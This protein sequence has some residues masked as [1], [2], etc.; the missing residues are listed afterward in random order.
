MPTE[1]QQV[2][3][4]SRTILEMAQKAWGKDWNKPDVVYEFSNGKKYESTDMT[5]AG[6]YD[7]AD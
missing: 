5:D 4:T 7:H 6:I 2:T 3:Y 1:Q